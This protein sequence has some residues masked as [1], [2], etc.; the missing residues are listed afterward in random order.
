MARL[1]GLVIH[2][3]YWCVLGHFNQVPIDSYHKALLFLTIQK[4]LNE[5]ISQYNV[6]RQFSTFFMPMIVLAIR[7]EIDSVFH[8]KY[9]LLFKDLSAGDA[10]QSN[11]C[12][13]LTKLL[14]PNVLF[15]RFSTLESGDTEISLK[16]KQYFS[17]KTTKVRDLFYTNSALVSS[18]LPHKAEGKVRARFTG[19]QTCPSGYGL[20]PSGSTAALREKTEGDRLPSLPAY[21]QVRKIHE[22]KSR[23]VFM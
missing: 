7:R 14:D 22:P 9:S 17:S 10:A 5:I 21:K 12:L 18:L 6:N 1:V 15:S 8:T 19:A 16:L 4:I 13:L 11:I 23:I 3:V 20:K 2:F